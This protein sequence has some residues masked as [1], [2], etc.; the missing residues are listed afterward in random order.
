ML[1]IAPAPSVMSEVPLLGLA[2]SL[3]LHQAPGALVLSLSLLLLLV[4]LLPS[5]LNLILTALSITSHELAT[6][7]VLASVHPHS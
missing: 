3:C 7:V 6:H 1:G 5:R 2:D 4:L